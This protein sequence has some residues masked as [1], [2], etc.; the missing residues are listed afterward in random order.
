MSIVVSFFT[1]YADFR[2][3]SYQIEG[4]EIHTVS[5]VKDESSGV[6]WF[7]FQAIRNARHISQIN[8]EANVQFRIGE[9]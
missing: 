7:N 4:N 3:L 6:Y 1:V 9:C 2:P 8:R 5:C